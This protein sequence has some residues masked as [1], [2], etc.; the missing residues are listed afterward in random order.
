MEKL[1]ESIDLYN[2]AV[3]FRD[4]DASKFPEDVQRAADLSVNRHLQQFEA[5]LMM[6]NYR[7]GEWN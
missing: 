6:S 5:A 4:G 7:C 1:I 2:A 3:E